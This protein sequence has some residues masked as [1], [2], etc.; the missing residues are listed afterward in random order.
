LCVWSNL[1]E[2][3]IVDNETYSDLNP[4]HSNE[5]SLILNNNI[6]KCDFKLI[7]SLN[8]FIDESKKTISVN[9]LIGG[10]MMTASN[11][12]D[13]DLKQS[14]LKKLTSSNLRVL[15]ISSNM[16][17]TAAIKMKNLQL[18]NNEINQQLPLD[19][20][21]L[22]F[23]MQYLFPDVNND[24]ERNHQT[25]NEQQL[26][27]QQF[28]LNRK[29]KEFFKKLNLLK[30]STSDLNGLL[31][32]LAVCVCSLNYLGGIKA[33]AQ[34]WSDFLLELRFR[35]ENNIQIPDLND[36]CHKTA[37]QHK[38]KQ[39]QNSTVDELIQPPDL[40]KCLLHQKLQM[41]NCCIKKR[42]QRQ[43]IELNNCKFKLSIVNA[44]SQQQQQQNDD[45]EEEDDDDDEFYDCDDDDAIKPDGRI[46]IFNNLY[47]LNKPNQP[48]Y[49]PITQVCLFIFF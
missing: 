38:S 15:D 24:H 46:K 44:N 31:N 29:K 33:L 43:K 5:W 42:L 14:S 28:Y 9:Q 21:F 32:R 11:S 17:E 27:D 10:T 37:K 49:V 48:L 18:N 16:I 26:T 4:T 35:Y 1:S 8:K 22:D 34:V 41:L 30:S 20:K 12:I 23:I 25:S 2:D 13:D 3:I 19:K 6:D 36:Y 40:S 7:N 45:N 47:L 39:N